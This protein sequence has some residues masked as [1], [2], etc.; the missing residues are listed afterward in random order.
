M[1][2]SIR[3]VPNN[4]IFHDVEFHKKPLES[5][6]MFEVHSERESMNWKQFFGTGHSMVMQ[7][8]CSVAEDLYN[9]IN[10]LNVWGA[11]KESCS[12]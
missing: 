6:S 3:S 4:H 2:Y 9:P 8:P 5:L 12:S 10:I 1:K 11:W 7:K